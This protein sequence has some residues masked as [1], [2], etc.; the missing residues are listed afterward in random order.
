MSI[1]KTRCLKI[2][3]RSQVE[4]LLSIS[5]LICQKTFTLNSYY[6]FTLEIYHSSL[7]LSIYI[8]PF[9]KK[10]IKWKSYG[11]S[12]RIYPRKKW[13]QYFTM[14][15]WTNIFSLVPWGRS[16]PRPRKLSATERKLSHVSVTQ[17]IPKRKH[18]ENQF[19]RPQFCNEKYLKEILLHNIWEE[20]R[21]FLKLISRCFHSL[22]I[23]HL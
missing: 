13:K 11:K 4:R 2:K 9:D 7:F 3:S 23:A 20:S 12:Q 5:G 18:W 17:D 1:K 21:E 22:I 16:R 14:K 6:N 8:F 15:L 19:K 10:T